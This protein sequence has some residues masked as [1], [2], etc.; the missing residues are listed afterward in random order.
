MAPDGL[1]GIG[2]VMGYA[3]GAEEVDYMVKVPKCEEL[4]QDWR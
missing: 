4:A 2:S 3:E 1:G